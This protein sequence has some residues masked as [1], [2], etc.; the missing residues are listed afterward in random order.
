MCPIIPIIYPIIFPPEGD[1]GFVKG[2]ALTLVEQHL[3]SCSHTLSPKPKAI[4]FPK[5]LTCGAYH[6]SAYH[7]RFAELGRGLGR[8]WAG[9]FRGAVL[10]HAIERI[11]T[12][13]ERQCACQRESFPIGIFL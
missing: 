9:P 11:E 13:F 3:G 5:Q 12:A 10:D 2:L 4:G 1:A 6:I 8:A 7:M